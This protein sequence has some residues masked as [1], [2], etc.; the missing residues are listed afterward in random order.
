MKP[1][2][3]DRKFKFRVSFAKG[4]VEIP[5]THGKVAVIDIQD[6]EAGRVGVSQSARLPAPPYRV[7]TG[8]NLDD[9][10][11]WLDW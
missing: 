2:P 6:S 9:E 4:I 11:R 1:R 8:N 3:D 5:L 10:R 7:P